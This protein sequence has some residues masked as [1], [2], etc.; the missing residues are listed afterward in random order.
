MDDSDAESGG[1]W[2]EEPGGSSKVHG[3]SEGAG[4]GGMPDPAPGGRNCPTTRT[5][6][7]SRPLRGLRRELQQQREELQKQRAM[8]E[9]IRSTML[10]ILAKMPP[11][12]A[13]PEERLP[14]ATVVS[15]KGLVMFSSELPPSEAKQGEGQRKQRDNVPDHGL[16]ASLCFPAGWFPDLQHAQEQPQR[17]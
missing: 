5:Q 10:L 9:S 16:M 7:A 3:G 12:S 14:T 13:P 6:E 2:E 4:D 8:L 17:Q 15:D 11:D 1:N